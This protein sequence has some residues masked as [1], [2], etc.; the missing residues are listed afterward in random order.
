VLNFC[1]KS[2]FVAAI[3]V[4][5]SMG[6]ARAQTASPA[7]SQQD[8]SSP[9]AQNPPAEQKPAPSQNS[10]TQTQTQPGQTSSEKKDQKT[11]DQQKGTSNDRI[12]WTLPNFLSVENSGQ[13]PPLTAGQKFKTVARGTF[14][15]VEF[16]FVGVVTFIDQAENTEP[17]Y[18]QGAEGY[19]KRYATNYADTFVENFMVGAAF[20]SVLHQDPRYYQLGKGSF[21]HRTVYAIGRLFVTRSDSGHKQ[22]NYSEIFG[23]ALAA[24]IST[25]SYHPNADQNVPNTASVW[26]TQVAQDAVSAMLKEFWP[27]IRRK[28]HK[29]ATSGY[30]S[31][32]PSSVQTK[33]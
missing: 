12:F 21:L 2:I 23:S 14:D 18:G 7:P 20:P 13:L 19:G 33:Q 16:A 9:P 1:T 31:S 15:P 32:T 22:F 28:F 6:S 29:K 8:Q 10:S 26:G 11:A 25:Y 30:S 17:S 5:S 3:L 4:L 24:S 27:D